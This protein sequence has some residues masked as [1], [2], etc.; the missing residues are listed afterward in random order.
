M[1]SFV[2]DIVVYYASGGRTLTF[3]QKKNYCTYFLYLINVLLNLGFATHSKEGLGIWSL[4]PGYY[5]FFF[6][7]SV[8]LYL[9]LATTAGI[10]IRSTSVLSALMMVWGKY[11]GEIVSVGPV[12]Y[13]YGATR[14]SLSCAALNAW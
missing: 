14:G 2:V 4:E 8:L 12:L 13:E 5:T 1:L 10:V 7:D 9:L 3:T 11:V 6:S